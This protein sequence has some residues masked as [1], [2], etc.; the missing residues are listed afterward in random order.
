[1][2]TSESTLTRATGSA[3]SGVDAMAAAGQQAAS[4]AKP[5]I[6]RVA[7]MAHDAVNTAAE[8]VAP[9]A[10]WLSEQG[11][12]FAAMQKKLMD[13]TCQYITANPLKSVAIA[14]AAGFVLSRLMRS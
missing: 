2:E 13:D 3:H 10:E 8:K 4:K 14:V 12:S 1:M 7:S 5:A 6:D 11:E 9:T